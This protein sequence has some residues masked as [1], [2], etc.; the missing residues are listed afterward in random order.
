MR[1]TVIVLIMLVLCL[2]AVAVP[3]AAAVDLGVSFTIDS[4]K[5]IRG[6]N[7]TVTATVED[8]GGLGPAETASGNITASVGGG[9]LGRQNFTFDNTTGSMT[10]DFAWVPLKTGDF[11]VT[12]TLDVPGD[13]DTNNDQASETYSVTKPS[14]V[15]AGD[16]SGTALLIGAISLILFFG[17]IIASVLGIIPQDRLPVQPALILTT[18]IIMGL[19]Y[20]GSTQDSS[21]ASFSITQ[22]S[23][24]I[25]I[26]PITALISG[27]LVAGALEAAGAFEAAADGLQRMEDFRFPKGSATPLFGIVGTVVVLTN[28][29]TIIAMP[30][31]R[32]LAA[33]LMPAALFFGIRV[34]KA[35][36]IPA[37]VSV[38]VFAFIVN[39]AA[40][41][42]P[43][44]IGG[45]GTIGEGLAALPAGSLSDAQQIGIMLATGVCAL[46]MRFV[47]VSIPPDLAEE[48]AERQE[49]ERRE[50]EKAKQVFPEAK[51]TKEVEP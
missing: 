15:A 29:P 26:H 11:P 9:D 36:Q 38:V 14:G 19:A 40:S 27:F 4:E 44:L 50:A 6:S 3:A 49:A 13:T 37:L 45:I 20:I 12:V 10:F 22:L 1:R 39:A 41:C 28:V 48:E 16:L 7:I 46:V 17:V 51:P 18:F 5:V 47:T 24:T 32:I 2:G 33:A 34:A 42:G 23:S 8:V 31:G 43:S 35:F 25:I 30:C 21:V